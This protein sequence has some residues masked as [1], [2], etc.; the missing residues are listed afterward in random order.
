[1]IIIIFHQ[2]FW[3]FISLLLFMSIFILLT[4]RIESIFKSRNKSFND[5]LLIFLDSNK[6]KLELESKLDSYNSE[7]VAEK[8][9]YLEEKKIAL[10]ESMNND[11]LKSIN[12]F[13]LNEIDC[14]PVCFDVKVILRV[15]ERYL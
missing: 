12:I 3:T 10:F 14:S 15:M 6:R 5:R 7:L 4:T 11:F 13:K 8:N 2:I 1:M 9:K